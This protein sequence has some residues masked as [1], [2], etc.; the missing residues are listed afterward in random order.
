MRIIYRKSS[1]A[2]KVTLLGILGAAGYCVEALDRGESNASVGLA[3]IIAR[4]SIVPILFR[5]TLE[6]C[7]CNARH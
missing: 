3:A 1:R 7:E 6:C 5:N 4:P 2:V